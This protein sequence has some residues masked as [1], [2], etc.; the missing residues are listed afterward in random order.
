MAKQI[1]AARHKVAEREKEFTA[2]ELAESVG[3]PVS[4]IHGWTKAGFL[5][6][7]YGRRKY[8]NSAVGEVLLIDC[9]ERLGIDLKWSKLAYH[10]FPLDGFVVV[11]RNKSGSHYCHTMAS[12]RKSDLDHLSEVTMI[13]NVNRLRRG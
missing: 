3:R 11:G 4:K 10:P 2:K 12:I 1:R 5:S 6:K 13:I 7:F 9:L 8:H